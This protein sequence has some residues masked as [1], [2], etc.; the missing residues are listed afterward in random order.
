MARSAKLR[1][2]SYD[3]SENKPR[4]RLARQLENVG[5]RVQY[6]VFEARLTEAALES[7]VLRALD[8]IDASDSLRVYTIG[9]S[10]ERYCKSYGASIPVDKDTGYWLL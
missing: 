7:V 5:T 10:G 2:L 9:R 1:I 3:V 8:T 6:S 4:R